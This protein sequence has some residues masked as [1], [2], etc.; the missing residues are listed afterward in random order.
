MTSPVTD[1]QFLLSLAQATLDALHSEPSP[2]ES[3]TDVH[4]DAV[5][6]ALQS[7]LDW[8]RLEGAASTLESVEPAPAAEPYIPNNQILSL[9]QSAYEEY[10]ESRGLTELPFDPSDPGWEP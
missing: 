3:I 9:L 2:L 6:N 4:P 10:I 1:R 8:A 7:A 5:K